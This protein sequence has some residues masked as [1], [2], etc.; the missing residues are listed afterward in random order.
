MLLQHER[1]S[2]RHNM[3]TAEALDSDDVEAEFRRKK[4]E[5]WRKRKRR[6]Q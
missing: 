5:R 2:V 6:Q 4:R 3:V 1:C